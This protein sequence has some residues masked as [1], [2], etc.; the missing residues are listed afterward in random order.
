MKKTRIVSA[1]LVLI[2]LLG[3]AMP[4]L[5]LEDSELQAL[6]DGTAAFQLKTVSPVHGSEWAMLGLVRSGYPLPQGFCERYFTSVRAYLEEKQGK[7]T[8][9]TEYAR[10]SIE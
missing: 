5:A 7:L 10:F 4:A 2:F 8:K 1:L 9:V 3:A 6:I